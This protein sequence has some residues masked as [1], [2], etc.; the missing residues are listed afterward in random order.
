MTDATNATNT[1]LTTAEQLMPVLLA[2]IS[3]GVKTTTPY[4]AVIAMIAEVMPPLIASFGANS[5]QISALQ[6]ALI[7]EVLASQS[8]YDDI[9]KQ[10]GLA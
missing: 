7:S 1:V 4:G 6:N 9:A 2:A 10:R 8:A 3:A 5:S